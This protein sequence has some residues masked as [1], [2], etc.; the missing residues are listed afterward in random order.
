ML[1][2]TDN[3]ILSKEGH[4]FSR[5]KMSEGG[6]LLLMVQRLEIVR[7][8]RVPVGFPLRLLEGC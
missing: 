1:Q 7:A 2:V 6:Q 5:N 3:P 8:N 4:V